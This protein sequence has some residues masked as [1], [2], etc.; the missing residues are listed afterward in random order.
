M[1]FFYNIIEMEVSL[2]NRSINSLLVEEVYSFLLSLEIEMKQMKSRLFQKCNFIIQT[3]SRTLVLI[4]SYSYS[5][6]FSIST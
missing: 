1:I 2:I 3:K 6:S 4:D 5:V